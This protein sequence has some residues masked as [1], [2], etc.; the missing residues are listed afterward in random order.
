LA[1]KKLAEENL[2]LEQLRNP[3]FWKDY[4]QKV[5]TQMDKVAHLL[6]DLWESSEKP[7]TEF[8]D[9]VNLQKVVDEA[10]ALVKPDLE[11]KKISVENQ[12][13]KSI[14]ELKVDRKN[15]TVFLSCC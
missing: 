2:N 11:K 14:P 10:I 1:P 13:S 7:T 9:K 5:Q 4:Y 8:S 6:S 12:I 3:D 15:S